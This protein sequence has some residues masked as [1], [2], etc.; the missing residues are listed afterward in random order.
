MQAYSGGSLR[1]RRPKAGLPKHF[2]CLLFTGVDIQ[3]CR[4]LG[5]SLI[6]ELPFECNLLR[7]IAMN[8]LNEVK[9]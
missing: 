4:S 1:R 2:G 7:Y 8:E 9:S 6:S 3:D 5:R